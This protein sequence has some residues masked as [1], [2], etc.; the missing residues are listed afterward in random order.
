MTS[1]RCRTSASITPAASGISARSS[2]NSS[3]AAS[4]SSWRFSISLRQVESPDATLE[5]TPFDEL[6]FK[7]AMLIS[8]I[9]RRISNDTAGRPG[10]AS[11]FPAPTRSETGRVPTDHSVRSDNCKCII[12]LGKQPADASEYQPVNRPKWKS[13]GIGPPQHVDSLPQHHNLC[14]ERYS[15]P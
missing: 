12:H 14:L 13:L 8:R 10:A 6:A 1:F 15:R 9:T 7:S 3:S 5:Q 2:S 11:R 4:S